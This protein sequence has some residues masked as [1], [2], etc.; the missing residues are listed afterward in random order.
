MAIWLI[1]EWFSTVLRLIWA[2][3]GAQGEELGEDPLLRR[4]RQASQ[5][6]EMRRR[7]LRA[8]ARNTHI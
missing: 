5:I 2:Y 4:E 1:F 6:A 3:S 7:E 8:A